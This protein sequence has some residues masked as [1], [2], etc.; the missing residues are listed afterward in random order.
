VTE[1]IVCDTSV[2]GHLLR[3]RRDW[4]G[5]ARWDRSLLGRLD[6]AV[7]AISIVTVAES[8]AGFL[9]DRWGV[10]RTREA[11]DRLEWFVRFPVDGRAQDEWAR[12][13]AAARATGVAI[14]DNDLWIAATASTRRCALATC[15][16]D[17]LRIAEKL[18]VEVVYMQPPV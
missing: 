4:K 1:V 6:S 2:V 14:G 13:R 16:K 12:L 3:S 8:R 17:H 7:L 15:D 9:I 11:N 18:P 10:R 5:H